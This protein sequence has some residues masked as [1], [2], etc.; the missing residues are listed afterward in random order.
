MTIRVKIKNDDSR[1]T[2][3]VGVSTISVS[4]SVEGQGQPAV[5][6]KGGEEKEF[7]VHSGQKLEVAEIQNG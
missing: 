6:L 1:E 7:W 5:P 4:G 2:A 3:I